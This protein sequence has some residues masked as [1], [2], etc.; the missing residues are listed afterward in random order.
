MSWEPR[1]QLVHRKLLVDDDIINTTITVVNT[2][3]T[4]TT[5]QATALTATQT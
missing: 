3:P 5:A 2:K 1:W 4:P